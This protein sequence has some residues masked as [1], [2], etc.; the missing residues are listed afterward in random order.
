MCRCRA[1][2]SSNHFRAVLLLGLVTLGHEIFRKL[3]KAM[4]ERVPALLGRQD[5][6]SVADPLQEHMVAPEAE[7]AREPDALTAAIA[8]QFCRFC[9]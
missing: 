8:K 5:E 4:N 6:H 7:F 3:A 9:R 1:E 2:P